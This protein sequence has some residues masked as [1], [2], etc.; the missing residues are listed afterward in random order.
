MTPEPVPSSAFRLTLTGVEV[1]QPAQEPPSQLIVVVGAWP[2]GVTVKVL[3]VEVRPAPFEAVTS[4]GS[5]GSV[6]PALKL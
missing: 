5:L 3:G 2:S 6:A 4:L 1:C